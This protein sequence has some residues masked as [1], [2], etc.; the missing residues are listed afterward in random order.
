META[1]A[2]AGKLNSESAREFV[3]LLDSR[4]LGYEQTQW[5]APT[6]T[7]AAQAFLLSVLSDADV[8]AVARTSILVAGVFAC[9]AAAIALIRLRARELLYSGAVAYYACEH[10]GLL[11]PR[12]FNLE[13]TQQPVPKGHR[14][15]P[16]DQLFRWIGASRRLSGVYVL[17]IWALMAFVVADVITLICTW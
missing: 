9:V 4:R 5:Q 8:S 7:I 12:P 10:A 6:L 14:V 11:D 13:D 15:G 17:W 2:G 1:G 16:T 3:R